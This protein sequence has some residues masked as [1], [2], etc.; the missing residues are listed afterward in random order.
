MVPP[1]SVV[2]IVYVISLSTMQQPLKKM[3]PDQLRWMSLLLCY[4]PLADGKNPSPFPSAVPSIHHTPQ[5][6]STPVPPNAC[7]LSLLHETLY[8][9]LLS[10]NILEVIAFIS[11]W[12]ELFCSISRPNIVTNFLLKSG[13]IHGTFFSTQIWNLILAFNI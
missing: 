13:L 10:N 12:F 6:A 9:I 2:L 11:H 4:L 7:I 8:A 5:E 3:M 1:S